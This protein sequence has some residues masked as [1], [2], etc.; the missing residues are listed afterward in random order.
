MER[1]T[2]PR[3]GAVWSWTV[4]RLR[5]KRIAGDGFEPFALGYVDLGP[6]KV[7]TRFAGR[8]CDSWE[9]GDRVELAVPGPDD[10]SDPPY[11]F[12]PEASS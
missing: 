5:P 7:E 2:L 4:Q 10:P 3:S 12:V 9:I 8:A 1:T 6:V 11:W